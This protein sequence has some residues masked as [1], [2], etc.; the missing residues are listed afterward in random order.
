[1]SP[2][3]RKR[4]VAFGIDYAIL[5]AYIVVLAGVALVVLRLS[6]ASSGAPDPIMGQ[7]VGFATLTAPFFL[8]LFFSERGARRA[9]PGKRRMGIRV[10]APQ[11]A[12]GRAIFVRNVLKLL[13]WEVAHTGVH[14]IWH[15]TQQGLEPP[16]WV[17]VLLVLPQLVG[18]VYL[19][20]IVVD[21]GS[22]SAYD[23]IAGTSLR[24]DTAR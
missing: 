2:L 21:R 6:G 10:D 24:L 3:L 9:T 8:Y 20:T 7:L 4:F 15:Y 5:S 1:M 14:W 23:R 17:L 11:Q 16:T 19:A 22:R 12:R 18:V 13:P